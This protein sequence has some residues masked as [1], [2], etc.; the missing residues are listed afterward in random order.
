MVGPSLKLTRLFGN[1]R[2]TGGSCKP[3]PSMCTMYTSASHSGAS[4]GRCMESSW[5][6]GRAEWGRGGVRGVGRTSAFGAQVR[7]GRWREPGSASRASR[8][9]AR[10]LAIC[11]GEKRPR[12][13]ETNVEGVATGW[14]WVTTIFR[15]GDRQ[16][17]LHHK[18][19]RAIINV[20]IVGV[21][22]ECMCRTRRMHFTL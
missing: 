6:P 22:R 14:H 12:A 17:Q 15:H 20:S 11:R 4:G 16:V 9:T 10:D 21:G 8:R 19:Q 2:G 5:T 18:D 1:G 3:S 13:R 7:N